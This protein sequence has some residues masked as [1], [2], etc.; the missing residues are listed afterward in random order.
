MLQIV[1][2]EIDGG[3]SIIIKDN[4]K[5]MDDTIMEKLN[6]CLQNNNWDGWNGGFGVKNVGNRIWHSFKKGSGLYYSKDEE[7]F[8][9]ANLRIVYPDE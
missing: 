7:G 3:I 2:R 4:G 6:V 9:V 8:T 5:G 1:V